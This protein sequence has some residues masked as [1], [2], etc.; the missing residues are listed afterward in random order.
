MRLPAVRKSQSLISKW[1]FD[2][3]TAILLKKKLWKESADQKHVN[4]RSRL[5]SAP[6]DNYY[7]GCQT[8]NVWRRN[9]SRSRE[10]RPRGSRKQQ[11][12]I[13]YHGAHGLAL[14]AHPLLAL[15]FRGF[16]NVPTCVLK[17]LVFRRSRLFPFFIFAGFYKRF[18]LVYWR[19]LFLR[20]NRS[21]HL[22]LLF[23]SSW[24]NRKPRLFIDVFVFAG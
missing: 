16:K 21:S 13:T 11:T 12:K 1:N 19:F 6:G 24:V 7:N 3:N 18:R 4:N 14:L 2:S 22:L 9:M 10:S 8:S 17:V 23:L 5:V 20:V 15:I